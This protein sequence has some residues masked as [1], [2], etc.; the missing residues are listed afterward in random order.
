M[1]LQMQNN[2]FRYKLTFEIYRRLVKE[3]PLVY[4]QSLAFL[5][6]NMAEV[7]AKT[8]R[9]DRVES[10]LR[11]ALQIFQKLAQNNP[12]LYEKH[13]EQIKAALEE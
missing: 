11:E 7:Y 8:Q 13:I 4:E 10:L 5:L 9:I 12:K 3:N 6:Y 1:A 2:T